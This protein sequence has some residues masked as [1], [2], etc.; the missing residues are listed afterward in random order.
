MVDVRLDTLPLDEP[1]SQVGWPLVCTDC[2]TPATV[3]IT[4]NW[5]DRVGQAVPFTR[6][7]KTLNGAESSLWDFAAL[8]GISK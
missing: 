5:H 4:P 7:W 8:R 3:N 6:Q 1:W 2:G